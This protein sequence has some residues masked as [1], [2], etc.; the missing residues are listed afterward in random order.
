M[1]CN[2]HHDNDKWFDDKYGTNDPD[3]LREMLCRV[4]SKIY[5]QE[6]YNLSEFGKDIVDWYE[7]HKTYD[8]YRKKLHNEVIG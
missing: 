7:K 4:L 8:E 2:M 1:G 3:K 6:T 5:A